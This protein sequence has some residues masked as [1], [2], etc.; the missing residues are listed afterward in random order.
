M[1]VST[2]I[3]QLKEAGNYSWN[4]ISERSGVPVST[5][6]SIAAGTVEQP[7]HQTVHDIIVAIG[8]SMDDL[9]ATPRSVREEMIEVRKIEAEADEDLKITIRTMR[10]IREEML[11]SMRDGYEHQLTAMREGYDR[12]ISKIEASHARE[13]SGLQRSNHTLR[14]S[15]YVILV[16]FALA[17]IT[18]IGILIYDITHLDRGWVQAF[19]G[20]TRSNVGNTTLRDLIRDFLAGLGRI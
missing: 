14:I 8:G 17:M 11:S 7:S 10:D 6:R 3:M 9:Y 20:W 13:L 2:Y 19:Y 4:Q 16:T 5:I 15:I 18:I 1:K 12:E